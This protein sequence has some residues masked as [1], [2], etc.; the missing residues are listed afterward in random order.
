MIFKVRLYKIAAYTDLTIFDAMDEEEAQL[1]A[2]ELYRYD[3]KIR[4]AMKVADEGDETI[5]AV[6]GETCVCGRE[7]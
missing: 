3:P 1:K 7:N 6:A 5:I 2:L 4:Q